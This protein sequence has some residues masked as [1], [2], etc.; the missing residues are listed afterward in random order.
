LLSVPL[1][2]VLVLGGGWITGGLITNDFTLSMVLTAV[3]V[4]TIGAACLL[5]FLRRRD[6]W[7][8]LAAFALTAG[9]AGIY[10]GSQT[11]IDDKVDED[12]VTARAPS[13]S[14]GAAR[15]GRR[16][17]EAPPAN[18]LLARGQF[19]SLEH[20]TA[21]VAEAIEVRGGR[22]VLTLTRF[23]TDNGPD[24]RVY[25]S[26]A[27]ASQDSAGEAF[28]DLG[29][30]KGNVGDQQYEIPRGVDLDRYSTVLV[31]CRAF[32]VGFGAAPLR[33]A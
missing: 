18:V 30:L 7:P 31:W 2:V 33:G 21:G 16:P 28:R 12:V 27:G 26:A 9:A 23:E 1:V 11:L 24:L 17:A 5:L 10:L 32:S 20:E 29:K 3:W 13:G 15:R 19:R 4:G 25:L 14:T 22:R 8:A 6:M